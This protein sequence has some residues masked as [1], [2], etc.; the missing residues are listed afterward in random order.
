MSGLGNIGPDATPGRAKG[1]LTILD[2]QQQI[3]E[4]TSA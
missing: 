4:P 3:T 1:K 2:A